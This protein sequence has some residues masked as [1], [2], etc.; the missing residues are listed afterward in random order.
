MDERIRFGR[1]VVAPGI[2]PA[3]E[4]NKRRT[5]VAAGLGISALAVGAALG[6][7]L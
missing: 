5:L 7:L 3:T 1:E 4:I 2:V 6:F